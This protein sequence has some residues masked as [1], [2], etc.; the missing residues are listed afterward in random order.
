MKAPWVVGIGRSG[1]TWTGNI[2]EHAGYRMIF[3]PHRGS[4]AERIVLGRAEKAEELRLFTVEALAG[5]RANPVW[6][7]RSKQRSGRPL[8]KSIR[9]MLALDWVQKNF[10]PPLVLVFRN[11]LSVVAS[12][13]EVIKHTPLNYSPDLYLSHPLT[14]ELLSKEQ[15]Q[16]CASFT[17]YSEQALA[18]WFICSLYELRMSEKHGWPIVWYED[19]CRNPHRTVLA[20]LRQLNIAHPASV[21]SYIRSSAR[22]DRRTDRRWVPESTWEYLHRL[23]RAFGSDVFGRKVTT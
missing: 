1:T 14:Q 9:L 18:D 2:L 7:T 17:N 3:E 22:T 21:D 15:L 4:F 23:D 13:L 12:V 6:F 11:P 20:L 8:L 16:L 5:K 10:D 19:L